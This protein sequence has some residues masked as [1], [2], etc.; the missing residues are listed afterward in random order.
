MSLLVDTKKV[1]PKEEEEEEEENEVSFEIEEASDIDD[2][3][4]EPDGNPTDDEEYNDVDIDIDEEEVEDEEEDEEGE[5]EED[6]YLQK[7]HSSMKE[8]IINAYH[9]ET[10]LISDNEVESLCQI[11]RNEKGVINDPYHQS[12]P[13]VTKYEKA[14][15]LG[16]RARQINAGAEPFV[17]VD[18]DCIDG[19]EIAVKEF[20]SKL[21]PFIV[22]RPMPNGK[23]EY[24]KLADL[25]M[26]S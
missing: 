4:D 23:C 3:P 13:F 1:P 11:I 21:I 6:G 8:S 2:E 10:K 7:F 25:E 5:V 22:K 9:P 15:I 24:W 16:E 18:T 19:Y 26:I 14:R 12:L 20:A 17:Q